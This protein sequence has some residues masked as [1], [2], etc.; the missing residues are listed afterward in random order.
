MVWALEEAPV[1]DAQTLLVLI[2]LAE[3]ADEEGRAAFP[4]KPWLAKRARCSTR[5]VQRHLNAL[6]AGGLII[7]GDQSLVQH[8]RA[9][10][11]P[12][13]Y[14]LALR[15]TRG[16]SVTPLELAAAG[17][18]TPEVGT[19]SHAGSPRGDTRVLQTVPSPKGETAQENQDGARAVAGDDLKVKAT[20]IVRWWWEGLDVK[21]AGQ[22]AYFS[23][24]SAVHAVLKVGHPPKAVATALRDA[25]SP[26][27]IARLEIELR[28]GS[29]PGRVLPPQDDHFREGG[30]W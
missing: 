11:R 24:I 1:D 18:E 16:D 13:V 15:I 26:V 3:R 8:Y 27:S 12:V 25:G 19:G 22:R 4:A 30:G 2:A 17:G 5:T 9:D 7:E 14:D 29:G 6:R 21:P 20:E 23:A 10:R 28:K